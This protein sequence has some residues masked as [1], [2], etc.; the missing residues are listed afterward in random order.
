MSR[1]VPILIRSVLLASFVVVA[2]AGCATGNGSAKQAAV[3]DFVPVQSGF[4]TDYAKLVPSR[5]FADVRMFRDDAAVKQGFQKILFRPVQVWRGADK[6][7]DDIPDSDL[8]YLADAFYRAM[9]Q[10]L[11]DDFEIA[12][13]PGP[14]VL[15]I[16]MAFTLVLKPNQPVDYFSANVPVPQELDRP[17]PMIPATQAFV[18]DCAMEIEFAETMPAA[19]AKPGAKGAKAARG[20]RVVRAAFLDDRRGSETPKGNVKTW[21]DLDKVLEKWSEGLDAQLTALKK[22]NWKPVLTEGAP[23]K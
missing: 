20:K 13:Q 11:R 2:A 19:G 18:R 3:P 6:R 1:S 16:S 10:P 15:E 21:R 9:V 17:L 7:L 8:Q 5:E 22:G 23:S 4:L 12:D 14:G